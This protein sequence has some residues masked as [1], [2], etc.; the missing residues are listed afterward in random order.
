M[1]K[2][3]EY[4]VGLIDGLVA[5]GLPENRI[6]L[7]GF[8]QGHAMTLLTALTT[9]YAGK[10]AGLVCLSGYLPLLDRVQALRRKAGLPDAVGDT[11]IFLV[12]GKNDMLIPKRYL[13]LQ[14]EKLKELG[15]TDA[16][17]EVHE[18]EGLGHAVMSQELVDLSKWLEKIVPPLE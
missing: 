16:A 18:Y 2:S 4:V 10:L 17:L 9:K 14:L 7:A 13:R 6:V 1:M 5:A 3:V 12:R 11:P 8:S 15:V